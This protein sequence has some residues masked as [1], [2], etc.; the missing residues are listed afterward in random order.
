MW[1]SCQLFVLI[2]GRHL[3]V[4]G[5]EIGRSPHMPPRHP[6]PPPFCFFPIH[7]AEF[8]DPWTVVWNKDSGTSLPPLIHRSAR[9]LGNLAPPVKNSEKGNGFPFI[10]AEIPFIKSFAVRT[11]L[12]SDF[13]FFFNLFHD[14][15]I[16]QFILSLFSLQHLSKQIHLHD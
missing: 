15:A 5:C 12:C 4:A 1:V 16:E 2:E 9:F 3:C 11:M 7:L 13:F 6:R 10:R 8:S 14:L